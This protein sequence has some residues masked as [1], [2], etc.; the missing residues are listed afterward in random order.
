MEDD[1]FARLVAALE[2]AKIPYM[3]TG[4]F[5]SSAHGRVRATE[6]IDVVIAPTAGQLRALVAAFPIDRFYADEHDALEALRHASQFN[7][8]DFA[9][10]WKADLIIRKSRQFSRVEFDRRRA[11][12]VAGV[13][14]YVASPEDVLIAKLEW[15]KMGESNR[16]IEDAAGIVGRQGAALDRAYVERWTAE[17]GLD[18]QWQMALQRAEE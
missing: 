1:F 2:S 16:Q 3:V 7:I 13:R 8:I 4:S 14:V 11:H 10:G 15:A 12:T 9:T 18:Q 6:D 17:L 5:A